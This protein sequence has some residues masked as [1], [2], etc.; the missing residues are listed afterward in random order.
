MYG[1]IR[2]DILV[3]TLYQVS[4]QLSHSVASDYLW[5]HGLQ[6]ARL[7]CSSLNTEATQTHV[8]PVSDAIQ[9]C[10]SLSSP[11]STAFNLSQHQGLFQCVSSLH[12]RAKVLE[13]QLQHQSLQ[14][15]L[16]MISFRVDWFDLLAVQETLKSLL[17]HHSS[18]ASILWHSAF[19]MVQLSYP[20]MTT[21]K[22]IALTRWTSVGKVMSLLYN[23]LSRLVIPFLPNSEHLLIS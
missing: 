7:P 4:V 14:W 1:S 10:H 9:P 18:K 21:G 16:K 17:L 19:F 23:T 2:I 22:I 3:R 12:H 11:S 15:I 8:H 6:N 5:P 13:L 20:Y